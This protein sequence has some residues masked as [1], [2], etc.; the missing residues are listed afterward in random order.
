MAVRR[1]LFRPLAHGSYDVDFMTPLDVIQS[2]SLIVQDPEV[3]A[4]DE[5]FSVP[6]QEMRAQVRMVSR[7]LRGY[8]DRA[9]LLGSLHHAGSAWSLI[10]HKVLRWITPL[11]LLLMLISNTLLTATSGQLIVPWLLQM[12]FYMAALGGWVFSKSNHRPAS[13]L[14][15]PFAFCLANVGFL[16]GLLRCLRQERITVY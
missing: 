9:C 6:A 3:L 14:S 7:N 8:L 10:S 4:S 5:M 2:N 13:I 11:F 12:M 1:E 16:R 15:A